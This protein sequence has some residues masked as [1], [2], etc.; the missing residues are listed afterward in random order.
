[1]YQILSDCQSF[2]EDNT[3][4]ILVCFFSDTLWNYL[5]SRICVMVD[6][7]NDRAAR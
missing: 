2:I 4:N 1:M 6:R 5:H 7:Q 3:K